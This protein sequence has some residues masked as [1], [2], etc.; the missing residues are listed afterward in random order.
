MLVSFAAGAIG[1]AITWGVLDFVQKPFRGFFDLKRQAV[2][3]LAKY[4]NVRARS[5]AGGEGQ[6][7]PVGVGIPTVRID[8]MTVGG[9]A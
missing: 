5:T 7:V 9:T 6:S 4:S 1:G 2:E 3:L 8:K